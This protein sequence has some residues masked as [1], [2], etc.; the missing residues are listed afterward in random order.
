VYKPGNVP[1][2]LAGITKSDAFFL[3]EYFPEHDTYELKL[4]GKR[5]ADY[6]LAKFA[7]FDSGASDSEL[8]EIL[9]SHAEIPDPI[10]FGDKVVDP[11]AHAA[12]LEHMNRELK[13]LHRI[14]DDRAKENV[15][16]REEV[17]KLRAEIRN[18]S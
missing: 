5:V 16:L 4:P 11:M 2:R 18:K 3:C 9:D 17:L 13:K 10:H 8:E 12:E 7:P 6:D 15:R 14:A 1:E